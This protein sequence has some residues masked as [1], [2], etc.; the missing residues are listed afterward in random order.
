MLKRLF[1]VFEIILPLLLA[2]AI[3]LFYRT[4]DTVVFKIAAALG[5][6]DVIMMV[7]SFAQNHPLSAWMVYS[8][9]GGL[10]LLAFQNSIAYLFNFS[11]K[12]LVFF[13]AA[14]SL[15][16][17]GLELLQYLQITDGRFDWID[18][19]FYLGATGFAYLNITLIKNKWEIYSSEE[20]K[21]AMAPFIFY[22]FVGIIYLADVV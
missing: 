18:V 7:K 22:V 17:I 2:G 19:F 11:H 14:A 5:F 9:P 21:P 15:V 6:G 10:W 3:Y 12:Y 16:G 4:N 20:A 1:I 13:V 8:L